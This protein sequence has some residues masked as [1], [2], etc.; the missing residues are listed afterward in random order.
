MKLLFDES[1]S[2][3]LVL[4]LRDLFP[5]SE[6]ALLNGLARTGDRRILDSDFEPLATEIPGAKVVVLRSCD[7]PTDVAAAVLRRNAIRIAEL[8]GSQDQLIILNR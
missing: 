3:K 7:Y 6:S 5:E 8:P 4:L 1:L 2:P